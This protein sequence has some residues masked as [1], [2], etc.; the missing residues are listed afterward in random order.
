[1][2]RLTLIMAAA[3]SLLA[4]S[5]AV[6]A[7]QAA[8]APQLISGVYDPGAPPALDRAQYVWGGRHYCWYDGGWHG[9]GY[10]WCGYRWRSGYGW[11]GGYGWRGWGGGH[12][13]GYHHRGPGFRGDG[14][15]GGQAPHH[16][17]R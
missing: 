15:R 9:P 17:H 12:P 2:P 7:A 1:M 3:A 6:G 16:H 4:G 8:P 10:Y 14:H 5:A 11:G 13:Y